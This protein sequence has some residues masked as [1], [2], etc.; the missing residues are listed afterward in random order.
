VLY[1]AKFLV[2]GKAE[3]HNSF[4]SLTLHCSYADDLYFFLTFDSS[5]YAGTIAMKK[6]YTK[7]ITEPDEYEFTL[8]EECR[9]MA[10][11]ELRE[12]KA[13]RDHALKLLRDWAESNPRIVKIRMDSNF[14]LRFLRAKKFSVPIV[15]ETIERYL[16]LKHTHDCKIFKNLDM[17]LPS[18]QKLLDLG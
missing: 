15:Q 1:N 12:T 6:R 14:L 16:L 9:Q 18:M 2:Q 13:A 17:N 5:V 7:A 4:L 3:T 10:E 11:M 8:S